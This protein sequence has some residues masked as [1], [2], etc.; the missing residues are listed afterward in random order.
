MSNDISSSAHLLQLAAV[1]WHPRGMHTPALISR[2]LMISFYALRRFPRPGLMTKASSACQRVCTFNDLCQRVC[3]FND[4]WLSIAIAA[5]VG[6]SMLLR[7]TEHRRATREERE[8][9]VVGGCNT[10]ERGHS[11]GHVYEF[12]G[13][14]GHLGEVHRGRVFEENGNGVEMRRHVA[15][16]SGEL[17]GSTPAP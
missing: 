17:K 10:T 14:E 5:L 9:V 6:C 8:R 3:T 2:L 12:W 1:V 13:K 15:M 4:L 11:E 7:A 16:E